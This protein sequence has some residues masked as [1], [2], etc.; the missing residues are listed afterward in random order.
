V[1]QCLR[2][3]N[4]PGPSL[5]KGIADGDGGLRPLRLRRERDQIGRRRRSRRIEIHSAGDTPTLPLTGNRYVSPIRA[6]T[7]DYQ[8]R[9]QAGADK[10][11]QALRAMPG[12][13]VGIRQLVVLINDPL[14]RPPDARG[15]DAAGWRTDDHGGLLAVPADGAPESYVTERRPRFGMQG[16]SP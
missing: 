14:C 13:T 9:R 5:H 2:R 8:A 4:A 12:G 3:G 1:S 11:L 16:L 7:F 10:S 6:T 15:G